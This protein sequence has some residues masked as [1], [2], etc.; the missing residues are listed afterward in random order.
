MGLNA[1]RSSIL[2]LPSS[3][4]NHAPGCVVGSVAGVAIV[5]PAGAVVGIRPPGWDSKTITPS[6]VL[7]AA[8]NCMS[9]IGWVT[10]WLV[11]CAVVGRVTLLGSGRLNSSCS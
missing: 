7:I 8:C 9:L 1:A 3:H 6:I 2:H 5:A 4:R 10:G 11:A